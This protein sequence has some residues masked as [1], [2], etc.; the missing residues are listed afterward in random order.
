LIFTISMII[1]MAIYR[2]SK[3]KISS[4]NE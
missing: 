4:A 1:G 2:W 3:N